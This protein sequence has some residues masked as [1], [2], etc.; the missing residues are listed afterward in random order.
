MEE[1]TNKYDIRIVAEAMEWVEHKTKPIFVI[2]ALILYVISLV[3]LGGDINPITELDAYLIGALS[4]LSIP[5][6]IIL[7]QELVELVSNIPESNLLSARRQFEI[8][9]LVI[10]RSF[11][12]KF[13]KLSGYVAEGEFNSTVQEAMIKIGAIVAIMFFIWLF[14]RM[15]DS[16]YLREYKQG[17]IAN[18]YKQI[19]VIILICVILFSMIFVTGS[20]DDTEFIKLVFTGIII[21]DAIFLLIAILRDSTFLTLV[22]ESSLIIALIFARFPLFASNS[23]SYIMSII[24]AAFATAA[25]YLM[26][27]VAE[28]LEKE[29]SMRFSE[30]RH[31]KGNSGHGSSE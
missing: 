11:F 28:I 16:E 14:R 15:A 5:F 20:F 23:L 31:A 7:L 22:F 10:I 21:I 2:V 13:D 26:Y 3:R 24:G 29:Y 25:L 30:S 18:E 4:N 12:K 19:L 27:R 1:S 8:V 17:Q 9:I 6:G